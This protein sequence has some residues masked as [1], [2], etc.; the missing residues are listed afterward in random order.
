MLYN[1]FGSSPASAAQWRVV[2]TLNAD[3]HKHRV[4]ESELKRLYVA[5]TRARHS[6]WLW[7]PSNIAEPMLVRQIPSRGALD[8]QETFIRT[9]GY[10]TI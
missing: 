5:I 1:F 2:E 10:P 8:I 9:I 4:I 3:P 6:I 7:D